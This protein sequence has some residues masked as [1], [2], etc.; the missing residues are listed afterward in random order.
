MHIA[1]V[2]FEES[3][4]LGPHHVADY[5]ISVHCDL[6]SR[7]F[8]RMLQFD[9]RYFC[10]DSIS[11]YCIFTDSARLFV[12]YCTTNDTLFTRTCLNDP[13]LYILCTTKISYSKLAILTIS[14]SLTCQIIPLWKLM[15]APLNPAWESGKR[16]KLSQWGLG[17][18]RSRQRFWCILRSQKWRCLQRVYTPFRRPLCGRPGAYAPSAPLPAAT[19]F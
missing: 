18:S 6:C 1:S 5:Q 2:T 4:M 10:S 15:W 14:H 16:C 13:I 8:S 3:H 11:T 17:R 19:G 7:T 9:G 12:K